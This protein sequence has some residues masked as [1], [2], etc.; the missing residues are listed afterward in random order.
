MIPFTQFT[1][2]LATRFAGQLLEGDHTPNGQACL[3]EAAHAV[4]EEPWSDAPTHWPDLRPLNDACWSSAA[5]RTQHLVPVLE[6][7]WEWGEWSSSRRQRV[8]AQVCLLT[9]T[10]LIAELPG[11][12]EAGRQ[13]CRAARTLNEAA[14]AA[15]AVRA[16]ARAVAAAEA[17]DSI[18]IAACALWIDAA[19]SSK[20][21]GLH[22]PA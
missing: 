8:I 2:L 9:V 4:L 16:A 14:A 15:R 21:E 13:P 19:E 1:H 6:A 5:V 11:L 18:L 17:A 20:E 3:L 7:Y 10:R 22:V 12:E